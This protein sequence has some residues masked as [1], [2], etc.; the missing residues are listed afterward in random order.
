MAKRHARGYRTVRENISMLLDADSLVEYGDLALAAQRKRYTSPSSWQDD[1]RRHR[2][3]LRTH[4]RPHGGRDAG[5]LPRARR[6]T[7]Y[8]H[9]LKLDRLLLAVLSNPVPLVLYAEGGG[10][11]PGDTDYPSGSGCT[12]PRLRSW[13]RCAPRASQ[14][15][16]S[17]TA[18]CLR[19]MPRCWARAMWW[20]RRAAAMQP[21]PPRRASTPRARAKPRSAWAAV[22]NDRGGRLGVFESDEI[23]PT[24]IHAATGGVD[25]VVADEDE[26]AALTRTLVGMWTHHQLSERAWRYYS[27][28]CCSSARVCRRCRAPARLRHAARHRAARRRRLVGGAGRALGYG[29]HHGLCATQRTRRSDPCQRP[30]VG[31]GW[32]DRHRG[33]LKATRLLRLL[34]RTRCAHLIS[35]CDTPGFMV[36]PE[37]ERTARGGGSFRVFGDWFTAAAEFSQ[38]GGRVVGVILRRAFGLGAQAMLGGSTLSNAICA[39]WPAASLG[40]MSLEGAVQLSMK[41]QLA[42]IA[43]DAERKRVADEAVTKLYARRQCDERG[44][45]GRDRYRARSGRRGTGCRCREGCARR[46]EAD[47]CAQEGAGLQ[48]ASVASRHDSCQDSAGAESCGKRQIILNK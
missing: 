14:S 34:A 29:H 16:A 47:V 48:P 20:W 11:R 3:G 25:V 36:G 2:D 27:A 30:H 46:E 28:T 38:S 15:S 40:P 6:N 18:T 37:F 22:R 43:D 45:H 12:R 17:P 21:E 10:G 1:G 24:A 42:A 41:K 8:M 4:A 26:A 31:A 19:A 23:G 5:R 33:A 7:G 9:H 13:A 35:L 32:G 44:E 39:A